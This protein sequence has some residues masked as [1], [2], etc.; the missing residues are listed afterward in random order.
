MSKDY[1]PRTHDEFYVWQGN[2]YDR[3]NEKLSSFKIDPDKFKP[4]TTA[5]S[6]YLQAFNRASNPD[7]ANRA[8]RVE[9]DER[10]ADYKTVIR[11]FVNESIRY[12]SNVSDYDKKYLQLTIPDTSPTPA[13]IPNSRPDLKIDSSEPQQHT[14]H[15]QDENLTSKMK[16]MGVAE[17]E[18]WH[19]ISETPPEDEDLAYIGSAKKSYFLVRYTSSVS[20]ERVYYKA[21]WVNT[22]GEKGPWGRLESAVI[23]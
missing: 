13:A 9:R 17:C 23:G 15:I 21:R 10:E 22:R 19:K 2:F 1:I 8:D 4:V 14:I 6:K 5:Q 16:P 18:I 3:A 20:G 11:Q 12:N 7:G